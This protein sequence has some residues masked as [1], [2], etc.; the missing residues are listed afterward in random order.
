[1]CT[2]VFFPE[3]RIVSDNTL[4]S[5]GFP[6]YLG[7]HRHLVRIHLQ[8][9]TRGVPFVPIIHHQLSL[10]FSSTSWTCRSHNVLCP[11]HIYLAFQLCFRF[12]RCFGSLKRKTKK[13]MAFILSRPQSCDSSEAIVAV[14]RKQF[15]VSMRAD[16]HHPQCHPLSL[17]CGPHVLWPS[18]IPPANWTRVHWQGLVTLDAVRPSSQMDLRRS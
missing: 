6:L 15:P 10:S 13:D 2:S 4:S 7:P 12:Q 11:F 8:Y 5:N 17:P 3:P 16:Y 14:L 1:V 9:D 18:P